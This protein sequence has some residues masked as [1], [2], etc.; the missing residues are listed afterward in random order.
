M[1]EGRGKLLQLPQA[2][3]TFT[4]QNCHLIIV[5][6]LL[7]AY[8]KTE[9]LP[10]LSRALAAAKGAY[11]MHMFIK[12]AYASAFAV[13]RT[14][15]LLQPEDIIQCQRQVKMK[16]QRAKQCKKAR[17]LARKQFDGDVLLACVGEQQLGTT[18]LLLDELRGGFVAG[19]SSGP[20]GVGRGL[21][22]WRL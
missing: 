21:V 5:S 12:R 15:P 20:G 6:W 7:G 1:T 17:Q 4:A 11:A 16:Q 9:P 14:N 8:T 2:R 3:A 22:G 18:R 19:N 10:K 13:H